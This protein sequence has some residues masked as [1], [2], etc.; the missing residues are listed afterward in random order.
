MVV[1][2][3]T[4]V[5]TVYAPAF[6]AWCDLLAEDEQQPWLVNALAR[7]GAE[8]FRRFSFQY[9]RLWALPVRV[10]RRWERRLR[11]G[12]AGAALTLALVG[13]AAQADPGHMI[14]VDEVNCTLVDAITAA[15]TDAAVGGCIAGSGAD[16][17]DLQA[18]VMLTAVNNE[19]YGPSGLPVV[20]SEITIDGNGHLVGRAS[21]A[22]PFRIL[23]I[24]SAGLISIDATTI[25][26]GLATFSNEW[27][28]AWGGGI[29]NNGTLTISESTIS[30][31]T[32]QQQY[33]GGISN[34]SNLFVLNSIITENS[35]SNGAGLHNRQGNTTLKNSSISQNR[36][37]DGGGVFVNSGVLLAENVIIQRNNITFFG[38]GVFVLDGT[39]SIS[40]SNISRNYGSASRGG[41]IHIRN[42]KL[43]LNNSILSENTSKSGAGGAIY[44]YVANVSIS[45]STIT[46]NMSGGSTL[47]NH[48][49][50]ITVVNSTISQ[51]HT[52]YSGGG[53]GNYRGFVSI[54][55]VTIFG[56]HA[57]NG[58]GIYNNNG[59]IHLR[60]TLITGNRAD[61][62]S[63]EIIVYKGSV[64]GSHNLIGC[65]GETSRQALSGFVPDI[66]DITAT[67]DGTRPS[68]IARI[69]SSTLAAN[70][71]LTPTHALQQGSPAV[72]VIPNNFCA[73]QPV[74][75]KDQRGFSRNVNGDGIPSAHECDIGAFELQATPPPPE[76]PEP[77]TLL[78]LSGGLAALAIYAKRRGLWRDIHVCK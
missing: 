65:N 11:L 63:N 28:D 6:A 42:G 47:F 3:S 37:S 50:T 4:S 23:S 55:N 17:I 12:L 1:R 68:P 71:G 58:G 61:V 36:G 77:A 32:A 7:R 16:V 40:N 60:H 13:P 43:S 38:G 64:S 44:N 75:G 34:S 19:I 30:G 22:P 31:N 27:R 21:N 74:G 41:G 24:G 9:H 49:G 29:Y 46:G 18:D 35:A 66:S 62:L 57:K 2:E 10:R 33:G 39:V 70:S 25:S 48:S 45:N 78:L 72:D 53:I 15:N 67:S 59:S 51:N 56:N 69:L 20:T 14:M 76:I 5:R 54:S 73:V 8:M 26:G 52:D